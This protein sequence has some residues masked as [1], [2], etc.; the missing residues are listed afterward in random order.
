M[1]QPY[2]KTS[3]ASYFLH[4][5]LPR[6]L[7]TVSVGL[8]LALLLWGSHLFLQFA[9]QQQWFS[10]RRIRVVMQAEHLT[11]DQIT[12]M[13]TSHLQGGFFSLN[14]AALRTA[15]LADPWVADVSFR[16]IWPDMLEVDVVEQ[17]PVA[18]WGNA[19]LLNTAGEVFSPPIKSFPADLPV[20]QGPPGSE[21]PVLMNYRLFQQALAPLGLRIYGL[22][23]DPSRSWWL[24]VNNGLS[25]KLG[26]HH[27]YS[28]LKKFIAL[29]P[30]LIQNN[31]KK[32]VTVDMRYPNGVAI[33]W[34]AVPPASS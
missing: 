17:K 28:R 4:T 33:Q 13:V 16:R 12:Q 29:Y 1:F 15:L 7:Y 8:A 30:R 6:I 14:V 18:Q 9:K 27:L 26:Q 25:I 22:S 23:L 5:W 34:S 31:E 11:G 19:R 24:V 21:W 20:L 3:A 32:A 10:F 2:Q